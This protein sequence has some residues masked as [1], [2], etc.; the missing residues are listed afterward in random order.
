LGLNSRVPAASIWNYLLNGRPCSRYTDLQLTAA[1]EGTI[2]EGISSLRHRSQ[3]PHYK[4]HRSVLRRRRNGKRESEA[5]GRSPTDR[6]MAGYPVHR[7][8]QAHSAN[9]R[10]E[11]L[12]LVKAAPCCC[13]SGAARFTKSER[14]LSTISNGPAPRQRPM[15][16][17]ADTSG[18]CSPFQF[19]KN[20]EL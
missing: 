2:H 7:E 18:C 4:P 3:R 19:R 16:D 1:Q 8:V 11:G 10:A 5:I 6:T 12:P 13:A 14:P 17:I 15:L 9:I 20:T